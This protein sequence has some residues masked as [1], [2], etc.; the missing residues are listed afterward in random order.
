MLE[1]GLEA[2]RPSFGAQIGR[3]GR[4]YG[5]GRGARKPGLKH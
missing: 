4:S 5:R 1:R 2:E 3:G